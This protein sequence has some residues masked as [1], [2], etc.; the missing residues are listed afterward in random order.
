MLTVE[1]AL[2]GLLA[3]P[4]PTLAI[5]EV[6][7]TSALGRV[8]A[9]PCHAVL[10]VPQHANSAMDGYAFRH[11]DSTKDGRLLPISQRIAAGHS[12]VELQPGTAARIFTGAE[13]PPGA[14]TVAMQEDCEVVDGKLRIRELPARGENV[15]PRAQDIAAGSLLLHQGQRLR[16]QDLGLLASQGFSSIGVY[17]RLRV[18]LV[19]TGDE[20]VEPGQPLGRGQIYNS[21]RFTVMGVLQG[22]GFEVID[23]G[24][25]P[26]QPTALAALL[27]QAAKQADVVVSTGGVSVGEEDHVKAVVESMGSLDLW[28]IAV[29]PG[30]PFAFG[31][32]RGKPFLGLPGN[33]VSVFVTLLV[34]ARPFLLACQ[35][36]S[37]GSP[38]PFRRIEALFDRPGGSREDYLRVRLTGDGAELFTS[39]SSG[40][41]LSASHSDGL[42]RQPIGQDIRHGDAVD[43]VP[44]ALLL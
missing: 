27:E 2:L 23:H 4:R 35:G 43:F 24:I 21:N 25:A 40:V 22:W 17:R 13:I 18:A 34:I 37:G 12:P 1:Q 36:L 11:A 16:P 19:S 31:Q 42:L 14:D 33:P 26:D 8:L 29:K 20:L 5:E 28:R 7:L 30:K 39:Q 32:V 6:A 3:A 10:D 9:Q 15:R 44:Y 38:V 41:L